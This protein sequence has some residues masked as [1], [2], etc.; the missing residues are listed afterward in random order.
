MGSIL[1][2]VVGRTVNHVKNFQDFADKI[3]SL[4]DKDPQI[5]HR[6][7]TLLSLCLTTI[8]FQLRQSFYRQKHVYAMGSLVSLGM[9][10]TSVEET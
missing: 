1:A 10:S 8:Y 9:T 5:R 3:R 2:L 7:S 4:K 6:Q